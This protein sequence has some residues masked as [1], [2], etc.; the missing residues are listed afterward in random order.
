MIKPTFPRA[1]S[2]TGRALA[3][4]M[5]GQRFTHRDFQNQTATYR[6]SSYIEHLRK[7]HNWIIETIPEEAP[8][9]DPTGR[10][11]TYGRYSIRPELLAQYHRQLGERFD[12]F[13]ESVK[14]FESQNI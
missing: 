14:K 3:R 12:N 2:L 9:S 8:T 1:E 11:A 10:N 7:T 4:L 5:Q 6:L 13:I